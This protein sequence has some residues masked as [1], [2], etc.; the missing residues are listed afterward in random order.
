MRWNV[1]SRPFSPYIIF[2]GGRGVSLRGA[3]ED[4]CESRDLETYFPVDIVNLDFC[5]QGFIFPDLNADSSNR[6][7]Y[8]RR[9][10]SVKNILDFN[11]K[12]EKKVWYLLLTLA[13]NRNN[14]DGRKYLL[15]QLEELSNLTGITKDTSKWKDNRLIQEVVPKIIADEAL[16][17]DYVPSFSGFDSYRYVQTGHKYRMVAWSFKLELDS[18]K[19]LGQNITKQKGVLEQFCKEYFAHEAK[20]LE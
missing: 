16:H 9:W 10:D 2:L 4:L 14:Q 1:L 15:S 11:S 3:I 13:C 17:R 5:G 18:Q 8:Q 19:S 7:E 20:E 6:T 12:K